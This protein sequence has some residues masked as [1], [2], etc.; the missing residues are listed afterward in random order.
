MDD[1]AFF[2]KIS[3]SRDV[4]NKNNGKK[5][6]E[7]GFRAKR[8]PPARKV[9]RKLVLPY[10]VPGLREMSNGDPH[11]MKPSCD[12]FEERWRGGS[13]GEGGAGDE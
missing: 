3:I 1:R 8:S 13:E 11:R 10:L 5:N 6:G 4:T 2:C 12:A 7:K 9:R